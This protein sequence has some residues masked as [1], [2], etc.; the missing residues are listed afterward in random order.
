[1]PEYNGPPAQRAWV[2]GG[3]K[4]FDYNNLTN[5]T[6]LRN[7]CID[8]RQD[9]QDAIEAIDKADLQQSVDAHMRASMILSGVE[10]K[11]TNFAADMRR[12]FLR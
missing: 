4:P 5:L 6:G 8:I 9:L 7:A 12:Q 2:P 10:I 1:M 3:H 11:M